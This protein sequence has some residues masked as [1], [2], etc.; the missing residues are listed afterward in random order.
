MPIANVATADW[1]LASWSLISKSD[2]SNGRSNLA[3][4][5]VSLQSM[6][7]RKRAALTRVL[8]FS[9]VCAV[10]FVSLFPL[11]GVAKHHESEN[12]RKAAAAG[13]ML[14]VTTFGASLVCAAAASEEA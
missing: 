14:G 10:S 4:N 6:K 9:S 11:S 7:K 13:L 8:F 12:A 5:L 3:F 1:L 2:R